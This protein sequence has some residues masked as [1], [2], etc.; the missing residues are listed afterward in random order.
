[1]YNIP[2]KIRVYFV[3]VRKLA[4]V[5]A[6]SHNHVSQ[7]PIPQI[8]VLYGD[9]Q[10]SLWGI[11]TL[12]L[13]KSGEISVDICSSPDDVFKTFPTHSYDAI[14]SDYEMPGMDGLTHIH[15]YIIRTFGYPEDELY[16]KP[17]YSFCIDPDEAI[18][19]KAPSVHYQMH[20]RAKNYCTVT[21][22]I[23]NSMTYYVG[24][25]A[26]IGIFRNLGE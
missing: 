7:T 25:P 18:I 21:A 5:P 1:P 10:K 8:S 6:V 19:R 20:T 13:E 15:Q 17:F 11:G 16:G 26:F 14:I 2:L 24:K 12:F 9:D 3:D 4:G 22:E 23:T